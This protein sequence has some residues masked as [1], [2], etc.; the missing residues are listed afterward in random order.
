MWETY[1]PTYKQREGIRA[2]IKKDKLN[3]AETEVRFSK[4]NRIRMERYRNIS[5]GRYMKRSEVER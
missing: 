3:I 5:T 4:K 1:A 2:E